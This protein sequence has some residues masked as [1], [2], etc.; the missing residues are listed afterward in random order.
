[1]KYIK[2]QTIL[3]LIL[4][5]YLI[6]SC[7]NKEERNFNSS[8]INEDVAKAI[9]EYYNRSVKKMNH[10]YV[11]NISST[12]QQDT[13]VLNISFNLELGS[14]FKKV[15]TIFGYLDD[16]PYVYYTGAENVFKLNCDSIAFTN[17]ISKVFKNQYSKYVIGK[18][19]FPPPSCGVIETVRLYIHKDKII[20]TEYDDNLIKGSYEIR[21]G[22]KT[23]GNKELDSLLKLK[24]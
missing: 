19:C 13:L 20:R 23:T 3:S 24:D 14:I 21:N 10:E 2:T 15:P 8:I 17:F 9:R 22:K 4:I 16:I 7:N 1:M 11:L 12:G 6:S 5:C 18:G